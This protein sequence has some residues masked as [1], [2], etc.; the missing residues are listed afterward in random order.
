MITE[1][2]P[3][4]GAFC[5]DAAYPDGSP[6]PPHACGYVRY[7][8]VGKDYLILKGNFELGPR[9]V[10]WGHSGDDVDR[11]GARVT[12]WTRLQMPGPDRVTPGTGGTRSAG[13]VSQAGV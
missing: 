6:L 9:V 5:P 11:D 10:L 7:D 8:P 12:A 4:A 1:A 3:G 2:W 13:S